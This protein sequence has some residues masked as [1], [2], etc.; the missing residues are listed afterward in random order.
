[1]VVTK[2][3]PEQEYASV[4]FLKWFTEADRNL[5]FS[6][7]SGYLPVKKGV[8]TKEN[9]DRILE[10][11]KI[12]IEPK[13]Y[14]A[15]LISYDRSSE[16]A[17]YTNK[18]FDGGVKARKVLEYN[19]SDKAAADREAVLADLAAGK[20][21]EEALAPYLTEENFETWFVQFQQTL[22]DAVK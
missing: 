3:T 20:S 4:V 1:M 8:A 14:D 9:L 18:A 15:L 21:V 16:A 13:A 10:E 11:K 17:L 7:G 6:S 19:L 5:E 22:E 12:E 2:S